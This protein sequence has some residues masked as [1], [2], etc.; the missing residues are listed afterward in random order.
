MSRSNYSNYL[1][2]AMLA[3][4]V[5]LSALCAPGCKPKAAKEPPRPSIKA[6][7][8]AVL[9]DPVQKGKMIFAGTEYSTT[10]LTCVHCHSV[11]AAM[12]IDRLY[13]AHSAYG[14]AARGAWWIKDQAQFD[15]KQG[16]ALTLA[17]AANK[18][19]SAPYMRGKQP[20][21]P[22]DAEAVEA[23]FQSIADPAAKDSAPF[24]HAA[25]T[26]PL[27]AGLKPDKVNGKRI[28]EKS[29]SACHGAVN[30]VP[31]MQALKAELNPMQFMAKLRRLPD[32]EEANK[33]AKYVMHHWPFMRVA[34]AFGLTPAYAQEPGSGEP[35]AAEAPPAAGAPPAADA[36]PEAAAGAEAGAEAPAED[37]RLFPENS[38]PIFAPDILSD[39]DVV[40]VAFYISEDL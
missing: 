13:I 16:E 34:Q 3:L 20:L 38:M 4:A 33:D 17:D 19:I 36:A 6:P 8:R 22:E 1:V 31:D 29:C 18:C 27:T 40:D 15:A 5:G 25:P 12:D 37:G 39:Q 24:I 11:S 10:G 35:P 9:Q 30:G 14:A 21:S 7:D 28:F 26:A 2:L 32:W 23:F